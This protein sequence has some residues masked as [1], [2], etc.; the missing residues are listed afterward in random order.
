MMIKKYNLKGT[1]TRLTIKQD[2]IEDEATDVI[3]NWINKDLRSGPQPFYRI[4]RKAGRQLFDFCM[5]YDMTQESLKNCDSFITMPGQL[6]CRAVVHSIVPEFKLTYHT[7]WYNIARVI[8]TYMTDNKCD[9]VSL[10]IP[11]SYDINLNAIYELLFSIGLK[12]IVIVC[13]S[14]EEQELVTNF[15]RPFRYRKNIND[16]FETFLKKFGTVKILDVL[17]DRY[18]GRKSIKRIS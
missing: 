15:F 14:D 8:E 12:D 4:H 11:D 2:L 17:I 16:L 6:D 3:V 1:N 10:Y 18:Y 5:S 9:S 13:N 7:S